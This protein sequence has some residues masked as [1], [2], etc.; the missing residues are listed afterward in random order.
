MDPGLEEILLYIWILAPRLKAMKQTKAQRLP[1]IKTE[2]ILTL[3]KFVV[4]Q[5]FSKDFHTLSDHASDVI[6]SPF[7]PPA[8]GLLHTQNFHTPSR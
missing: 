1:F 3:W 8:R 5:N 7:G 2:K 4:L 6:P